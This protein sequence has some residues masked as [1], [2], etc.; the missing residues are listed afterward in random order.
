M[1]GGRGSRGRGG[2][3]RGLPGLAPGASTPTL[4]PGV[5]VDGACGCLLIMLARCSLSTPRGSLPTT[6]WLAW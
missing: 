6:R 5:A 3:L 4:C 1:D 2:G